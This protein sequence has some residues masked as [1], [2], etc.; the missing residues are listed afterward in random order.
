L[1]Q[2]PIQIAGRD[3]VPIEILR[4]QGFSSAVIVATLA[5]ASPALFTNGSGQTSAV[6]QDGTLNSTDHPAAH[7]SWISLYGT[8][9]GIAALPVSARIGGY[10]A[11][12]L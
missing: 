1:V 2:A 3:H 6:N 5:D 12:V 11:E 4:E 8:G 10:A 9:E 7:G